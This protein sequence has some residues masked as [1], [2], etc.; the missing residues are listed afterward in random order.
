MLIGD[1]KR[2]DTNSYR[3]TLFSLMKQ[4]I[5]GIAAVQYLRM[6]REITKDIEFES[7]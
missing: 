3:K 6:L 4:N 1:T 7:Q 2:K 5:S